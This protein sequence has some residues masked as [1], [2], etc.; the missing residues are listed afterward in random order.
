MTF[1]NQRT[2]DE[3]LI[4]EWRSKYLDYDQ[5]KKL[6]RRLSKGI[7]KPS[8]P[9]PTPG[10]S[11]T[12]HF[13]VPGSTESLQ[14]PS[15]ALQ[16]RASQSVNSRRQNSK[17]GSVTE[18]STRQRHALTDQSP[19]LDAPQPVSRYG[20]GMNDAETPVIQNG[21][22]LDAFTRNTTDIFFNWLGD[23][24]NKV[25]SFY[26]EKETEAANRGLMLD[27]QIQTLMQHKALTK[28]KKRPPVQGKA[29]AFFDGLDLPSLPACFSKNEAQ[30]DD[31]L[32]RDYGFSSEFNVVH[33]KRMIKRAYYDYYQ[34]LLKLKSYRALNET[35]IRK[36]VKK[37]DKTFQT[38][39]LDSY[40]SQISL[41]HMHTSKEL[42]TLTEHVELVYAD[43][44]EEGH[45][46]HAVEKLQRG[47]VQN[48]HNF[49]VLA[50][51]LLIG[52]GLPLFIRAIYA[53]IKDLKGGH[54]F[55][56]RFY[57]QIWAGFFFLD[58]MLLLLSLNLFVWQFY[59]INYMFIFE[60]DRASALDY[61]QFPVLPALFFF[62]MSLFG[63]INFD[64]DIGNFNHY[65]PC[66]FLG[67]LVFAF[68]APVPF[69]WS[70]RKWVLIALYRLVFS[71]LYPVEFRDFFLGDIFCS[72]NYS[73]SN[74]ALFFC[75]YG[76]GSWWERP[77]AATKCGSGHSRAMG[78]LNCLPAIWRFLQCWRRFADTSD[79]FPHL[80]NASKYSLTILYNVFL[81][82]V[83][84]NPGNVPYRVLFIVFAG[85]NAILSSLWDV[86]MDFSLG[87]D[88]RPVLTYPRWTY[89]VAMVID[90]LMRFHWTLYVVYWDQT[91]Q[92]AKISF[93]VALIEV[94]RRFIW[95]FF[96]V[97][98]EHASNVGNSRAFK[99]VELP[100][101]FDEQPKVSLSSSRQSPAASII[102]ATGSVTSTGTRKPV[103][104]T[105]PR[106]TAV[107][108]ILRRA[109]TMDF[110]RRQPAPDTDASDRDDSDG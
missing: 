68:V 81:S 23:E 88:L 16:P 6:I 80:L 91:E 19:L 39:F 10:S 110:Q 12:P 95:V 102:A 9:V 106:F 72:L 1:I 51:G 100:Y 62:T 104:D 85:L 86:L 28:K 55:A 32:R 96:R 31:H 33:A 92:S 74:M 56:V 50:T 29:R 99:D 60:I 53:G 46:K 75:L 3:G 76:K 101:Y 18:P 93:I 59:K 109:H 36:I 67:I 52:A 15:P 69:F 21:I 78:F 58:L 83:R 26:L 45:R 43:K 44:F 14:L 98:N 79:W 82:F 94:V 90:P 7:E 71:G 48:P 34:N 70:S 66:L 57:L 87:A 25:E 107:Q 54:E 64:V 105:S 20:A 84:I 41:Y 30:P 22:P 2:L 11:I 77:V 103:G 37:F 38:S 42:D 17:T 35:G 27:R 61:R 24:I 73:V 49:A 47:D 65:L 13:S 108:R 40:L 63:W 5:G 89:Y 4:P 97:E 8:S